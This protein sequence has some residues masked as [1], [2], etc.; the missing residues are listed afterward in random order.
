MLDIKILE[1]KIKKSFKNKD[2]LKEALTHRSYINE[3]PSWAFSH[4]ERLEFLGDAVLEL[5]VTE[6]LFECFPEYPE[7]QLTSL[8]ASLVNYQ[9]MAESAESFDL[10]DFI[11]LSKGEA[12]DIGRARKVILANAMEALIGA[13][14]LD[15]GYQDA[16]KIIK[17]FIIDPNLDKII[18]E[19][20]YKD[21]KSSLQE[22]I[23][24]KMKITPTYKV[25]EEWGPDHKKIFKIGVYFEDKLIAKGEGYSKQEAEIEAASNALKEIE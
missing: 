8:R 15:S 22:I 6:I 11:L 2:F 14:H 23:Q 24:E 3:N 7:G 10:G 18:K 12:K 1:K 13:I 25:L 19:A 17:E 21:S 20:L 5:V 4:N 9:I 16:K